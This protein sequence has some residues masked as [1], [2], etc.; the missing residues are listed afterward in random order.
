MQAMDS[1]SPDAVKFGAL[2]LKPTGAM[3]LDYLFQR[4]MSHW[5]EI[6][7]LKAWQTARGV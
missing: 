1:F 6:P 7:A 5:G 3:R 4:Y 2:G